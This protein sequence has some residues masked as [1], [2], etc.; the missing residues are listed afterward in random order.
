MGQPEFILQGDAEGAVID[1]LKNDTPELPHYPPH[2]TL[3]ISTNL[4]GYRSEDRWIM[5]SQE[6]AIDKWPKIN[7][8][9]I[10]LQVYAERR[11]VAK[12]IIEICIASL[13]RAMGDYVGFGLVLCDVKLEQGATRVPDRLEETNRYV[14]AVRLTV[15]PAS[16]SVT[17]PFS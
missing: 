14:A 10:D 6:G 11:S 4:V 3:H 12:D 16:P 1:I 15:V 2:P 17:V 8:P 7:R 5:V 9:R 13:K